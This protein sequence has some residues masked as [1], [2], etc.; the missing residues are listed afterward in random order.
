MALINL[1]QC[2]HDPVILA[3][4]NDDLDLVDQ[5]DFQILGL[6]MLESVLKIVAPG[7]PDD[8]P[9]VVPIHGQKGTKSGGSVASLKVPRLKPDA[10]FGG[11]LYMIHWK[12]TAPTLGPHFRIDP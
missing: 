3:R 4:P 11:R 2:T 10:K 7:D 1:H 12:G 8:D 5:D 6:I 9:F